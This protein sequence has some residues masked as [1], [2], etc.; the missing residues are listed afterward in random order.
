MPS[1][2]AYRWWLDPALTIFLSVHGS[3]LLVTEAFGPTTNFVL[4]D[5]K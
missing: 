2:G 5:Q 3:A 1:F 4:D